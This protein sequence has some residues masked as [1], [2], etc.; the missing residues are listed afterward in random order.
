MWAS[1]I[2]ESSS[3]KLTVL[4]RTGYKRSVHSIDEAQLA[5]DDVIVSNHIT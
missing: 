5:H 2:S 3:D 1:M 4:A